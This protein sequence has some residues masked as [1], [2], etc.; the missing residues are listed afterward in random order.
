MIVLT[1]AAIGALVG[2]L[3]AHATILGAW[4]LLPWGLGGAILGYSARH[5]SALAGAVYGFVLSFVF[6]LSVYS[7]KAPVISR[8][9]FFALLGVVGAVCG[10]ILAVVGRWLAGRAATRRTSSTVSNR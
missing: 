3:G 5:R 7:G 1:A 10:S 2:W 4:T 8:M 6:M 9:P